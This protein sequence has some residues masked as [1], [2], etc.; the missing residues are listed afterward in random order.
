M[1]LQFLKPRPYK[2][3]LFVVFL[4]ILFS[5]FYTQNFIG[6]WFSAILI[7][8]MIIFF[9]ILFLLNIVGHILGRGDDFSYIP[10]Y[11]KI[12]CY[13]L[14]VIYSYFIAS[15]L[16]DSSTSAKWIKIAKSIVA[17][18]L[19]G[20]GVLLLIWQFNPSYNPGDSTL[21]QFRNIYGW[22]IVGVGSFIT[23]IILLYHTFRKP[24]QPS[25]TNTN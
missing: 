15:L 20:F 6:Y 4:V 16:I 7:V 8:R 19:L 25:L 11:W 1:N 13:A 3:A 18:F 24:K 14:G 21:T 9:P 5:A 2:I 17:I 23:A 10:T 12:T 22:L